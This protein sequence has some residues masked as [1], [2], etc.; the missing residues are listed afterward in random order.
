MPSLSL[1]NKKWASLEFKQ[2]LG[3][4]SKEFELTTKLQQLGKP[5]LNIYKKCKI[6]Q[7]VAG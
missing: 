6:P 1:R 2:P 5:E 3:F 7:Q 4:K